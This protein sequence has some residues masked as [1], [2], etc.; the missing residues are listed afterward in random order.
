MRILQI[1]SLF[2]SGSTG[3]ICGE[4]HRGLREASIESFVIYGRGNKSNEKNVIK[5][6]NELYSKINHLISN[7]TG[8]MYDGCYITTKKIINW[9]THIN[10]DIVHLQCI[11]GNIVNIYKLISY[12]KQNRVPTILTLHAEFMY[13]GNCGHSLDCQ[14]WKNG[15]GHC[16]RVRQATGSY[17][18]DNS[19]KSWKKMKEA[20]QGFKNIRIIAVSKWLEDRAKQSPILRELPI[21]TIYNGLNTTIFQYKVE[22]P[23]NVL[24]KNNINHNKPIILHATPTFKSDPNDLKGGYYIIEI[25][26]RLPNLQFVIAGDYE[27][28][29][30]LPSNIILLGKIENQE[31]LA[32]WY[33][34]ANLTILASKRE[35]FSMVCAES[36]CCGTPVVGFRAGG[37][38]SVA[39]KEY[40]RFV[41]YGDLASLMC[42]IQESLK[43]CVDK[44]KISEIAS[45]KYSSKVML[46]KYIN[47]YYH[48]L[49][50]NS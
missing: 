17:F 13:T 29:N 39:L 18:V 25:A 30:N 7:I 36:L 44:M 26:K 31:E 28:I 27:K 41:D 22:S 43:Q 48:L 2:D 1:N 35:T 3:K 19:E 12:L 16:P 46:N 9:I 42:V 4:L 8:I 10:P 37:L 24:E 21:K 34:T 33:S 49:D 20:F 38:E 45:Q 50:D 47:E 40:S 14:N 11:N 32:A 6:G 15:C 23:I 5:I